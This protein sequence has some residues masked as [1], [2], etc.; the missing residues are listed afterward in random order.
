MQTETKYFTPEE[1]NRTLPLVKKIV[2]DILNDASLIRSI[3]SSLASNI[4][5]DPEIV[6]LTG[7]IKGYLAE[8]EEIGCYFK[9]WNFQLGLVD[10]PAI[11][12]GEEVLLCWRSDED[13][14]EYFHS[15]N[16]GYTGRKL[17]GEH[18]K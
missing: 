14:I 8:L 9:D 12:N 10:F 16:E 2:I 17:I 13:K 1:A 11:I 7:N 18:L 5:N 4:E 6:R 15:V 3:S